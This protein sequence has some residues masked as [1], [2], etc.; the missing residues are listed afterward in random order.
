MVVHLGTSL[1]LANAAEVKQRLL[2]EL[3]KDEALALDGAALVELDVAGLQ[4][5]C[6][7]HRLAKA[8]GKSIGYTAG[9]RSGLAKAAAAAGFGPGRGCAP[10]CLCAGGQ[11]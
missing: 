5:L 3:Q 4:L 9:A 1:T 2:L 10:E 11:S 8:R 7:T 6:A